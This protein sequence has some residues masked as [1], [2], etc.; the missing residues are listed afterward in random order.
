MSKF[1]Y[2]DYIKRNKFMIGNLKRYQTR[3]LLSENLLTEATRSHVGVVDKNGNITS[4]YVHLD[5]YPNGVGQTLK[6][7]YDGRKTKQLL[8]I[9]GQSGVSVLDKDIKG[10]PGHTF[11]NRVK[12][13]T[14][15]YGRDRGDKGGNMIE[16]GNASKLEKYLQS[17]AETGAEYAYLYDEN[18]NN[19]V[20][21]DLKKNKKE[22]FPL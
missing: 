7:H 13:Q 8:K 12:G 14:L 5:G 15:F 9:A 2:K 20:Y 18:G 11:D 17:V 19:W 3:T 1:D 22:V 6:K 4:T 21:A 16:K 10:A